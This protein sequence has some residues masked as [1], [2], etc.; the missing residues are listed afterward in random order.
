M[1][2]T[3]EEANKGKCKHNIINIFLA[4]ETIWTLCDDNTEAYTK[5]L[6]KQWDSID[7]HEQKLFKNIQPGT[8]HDDEEY[9]V[10]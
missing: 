1:I 10:N 9:K 4:S 6:Q 8:V 7:E 2:L 3:S 5:I